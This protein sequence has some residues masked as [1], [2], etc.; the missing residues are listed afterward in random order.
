MILV[1]TVGLVV[2][3]VDNKRTRSCIANYMVADQRNTEARA[4]LADTERAA[5]NHL[6]VVLSDPKSSEASRT[7]TFR[8]Y[9]A[10]VQEDDVLRKK[11]PSL[12]VPSRCD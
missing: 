10:L 1:L 11:N 3:Y 5:F 4:Q 2:L 7:D 9:V 12:P 8:G 6:L